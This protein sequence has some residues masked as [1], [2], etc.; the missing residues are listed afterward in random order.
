MGKV[1]KVP[2]LPVTPKP[3]I[4]AP[5]VD[6]EHTSTNAGVVFRSTG[7]KSLAQT[8]LLLPQTFVD[9]AGYE[10]AVIAREVI[11][12]SQANYVPYDVGDLS[13]SGDSDEYVPG[14]KAE[15]VQIAMWFGGEIGPEAKAHGVVDVRRYALEQ[16]ENM[17]FHHPAMNFKTGVGGPVGGG[18]PGSGTGGPKYL[19]R[20]LQKIEHTVVPRLAA[21][22][23]RVG[24]MNTAFVI[25]GLTE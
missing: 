2:V 6:N 12:D 10:M 3:V 25:M 18:P 16:H 21:A 9:A 4:V 17:E 24:D 13:A 20:P 19:E 23:A 15:T 5:T 8:L 11:I 7:A 14:S 1:W 22:I